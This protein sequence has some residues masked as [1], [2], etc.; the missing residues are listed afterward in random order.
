MS[1]YHLTFMRQSLTVP[2]T[3]AG[4]Q[5]S[6]ALLSLS[7]FPVLDW[8]H[9]LLAVPG[10]FSFKHVSRLSGGSIAIAF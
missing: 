5:A 7:A 1:H 6:R 4:Q 10:F 9:M 3:Q 8:R 2:A